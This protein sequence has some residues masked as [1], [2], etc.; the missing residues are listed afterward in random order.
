MTDE[1]L[2][3]KTLEDFDPTRGTLTALIR[4]EALKLMDEFDALRKAVRREREADNYDHPIYTKTYE[5]F[6]ENYKA[7]RALVDR[8]VAG[9]KE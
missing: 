1:R 9:E 2:T 6:A 8:L 3:R 5:E 7:A 4:D